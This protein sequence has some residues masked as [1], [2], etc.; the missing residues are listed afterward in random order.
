MHAIWSHQWGDIVDSAE[1]ELN[2]AVSEKRDT[3]Q[4]EANLSAARSM[5][6]LTYDAMNLA[7]AIEDNHKDFTLQEFN[8][9]VAKIG[10][11]RNNLTELASL[12]GAVKTSYGAR[13][14]KAQAAG[15]IGA[16]EGVAAQ[17]VKGPKLAQSFGS[18][19]RGGGR[20]DCVA[21]TCARSTRSSSLD[22]NGK[23][24]P[25]KADEVLDVAGLNQQVINS[26]RGISMSQ[27]RALFRANG[28]NLGAQPVSSTAPVGDYAV[29]LY[30]DGVPRHMAYGRRTGRNE[31]YID[32]VQLNQRFSGANA[33]E[34]LNRFEKVEFYRITDR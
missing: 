11:F 17:S 30:R 22:D 14:P 19:T 25:V 28:K 12:M 21:G 3:G 33:R 34:Y 10:G 6:A 31:F 32:D 4:A 27:A 15:M 26:A 29:V 9:S 13:Q 16:G 2:R 20:Y 23:K 8:V 5:H 7:Y 24:V 18:E 1:A